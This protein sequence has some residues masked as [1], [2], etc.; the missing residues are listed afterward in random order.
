MV[1]R[2]RSVPMRFRAVNFGITCL[3]MRLELGM[4][5]EQASQL[6][7]F[8]KSALYKYEKGEENNMKVQNF[9]ALCNLYD[10][11]PRDYFELES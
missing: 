4:S 8:D 2:T 5:G 9:L 11:D 7:P 6:L 3:A 10:L 1:N